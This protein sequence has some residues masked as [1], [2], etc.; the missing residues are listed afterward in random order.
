[1]T[2]AILTATTWLHLDGLSNLVRRF[3]RYLEAR[4]LE[5]QTIAELSGLNDRDLH[6]LGISRSEIRSIAARS[7]DMVKA[8]KETE[9]NMNLKGWV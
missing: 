1:M 5:R 6:D 2:Q 9:T 8:E 4:R 3:Q 7:Y